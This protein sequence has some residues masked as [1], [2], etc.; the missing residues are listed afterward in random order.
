MS[1]GNPMLYN[2]I[3]LR[4]G[5][6]G[7]IYKAVN[8]LDG[9][10]VLEAYKVLSITK[11]FPRMHSHIK[12]NDKSCVFRSHGNDYY[13]EENYQMALE[14]YNKALLF[15]PKGS[16]EMLHAY[17][18]R[19]A[20]LFHLNAYS[21]CLKDIETCRKLG[22]TG[23]LAKKLNKR[24]EQCM[25][26]MWKE[27]LKDNI[28]LCSW[29]QEYFKFDVKKHPDISCLCADVDIVSEDGEQK[30]VAT[31]DLKI[32]TVVAIDTA[33]VTHSLP[34]KCLVSCHYCQKTTFNLMPC[35]NCCVALFCSLQCKERC[36]NE[37]HN[38]ECQIMD[39][40]LTIDAGH[41]FRLAI[42]TFLKLKS[43][44]KDW[45]TLIKEANNIGTSRLNESSLSEIYNIENYSSILCFKEDRRFVFGT[46]YNSAFIY[47]SVL[48]R[49][50]K[51]LGFFP[52]SKSE[53]L[54]AKKC[55]GK[56]CLTLQLNCPA[57]E[58][59]TSA[60]EL[61]VGQIVTDMPAHFGWFPFAGKLK[62]CCEANLLAL[63]LD[64]RLA[65]I[66]VR[67]IK[68]ASELTVSYVGHWYENLY[69]DQRRL[70]LYQNI[71]NVCTCRVCA[72]GWDIHSFR[73]RDLDAKLKKAYSSWDN[74][75]KN[76]VMPQRD[77]S[78][79]RETCR[80]LSLFDDLPNT[81]EHYA[82]FRELRTQLSLAQFAATNNIMINR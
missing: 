45:T 27:N 64:D 68:K 48:H 72:Q 38:I 51:V 11:G 43:L 5:L 8:N 80:T 54:E 81:K 52:Q 67:P 22:C 63:G 3:L 56:L 77:P 39:I 79:F 4:K 21:A 71:L 33:F 13:Q 29:A 60:E 24:Y 36:L 58:L 78:Y 59:V 65:L 15:A 69:E 16:I 18:N 20:L 6:L 28:L 17:G 46:L 1:F 30:I 9:S 70:K 74:M 44:C 23:D 12:S 19:S 55:F 61:T 26:S 49:L 7:D 50:E 76:H 47:A 32:G 66:A 42:K 57:T 25:E 31:K 14:M 82:V 37:Y 75:R 40:L 73:R 62:H 10:A 35:D 53:G 41:K 34:D 2:E